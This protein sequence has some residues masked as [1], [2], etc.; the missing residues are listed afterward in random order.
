MTDSEKKSTENVELSGAKRL[1]DMES[2]GRTRL[3]R[4]CG[5]LAHETASDV[6]L[7][8]FDD[9]D[10]VADKCPTELIEIVRLR[11]DGFSSTM[12]TL[13][14]VFR[15]EDAELDDDDL[16]LRFD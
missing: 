14:A 2:H 15:T 7:P 8:L 1:A 5:L 4:I 16:E 12:P 11:S 9:E 13:N 3:K 6:T 10:K